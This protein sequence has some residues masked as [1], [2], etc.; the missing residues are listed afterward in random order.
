MRSYRSTFSV[1][2]SDPGRR[3]H[4]KTWVTWLAAITSNHLIFAAM[5]EQTLL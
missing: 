1:V 5:L 3:T 2:D 4:I